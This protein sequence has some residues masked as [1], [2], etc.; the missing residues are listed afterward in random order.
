[1]DDEEL[2]LEKIAEL[3]ETIESK[4]RK[5]PECAICGSLSDYIFLSLFM[6]EGC[7]RDFSESVDI[8][9]LC[10]KKKGG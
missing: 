2:T 6:C 7:V 8:R 4:P 5:I 1:M 10:L 3:I 9:K